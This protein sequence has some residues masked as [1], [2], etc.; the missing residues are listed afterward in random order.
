MLDLKDTSRRKHL[1]AL[2]APH[3]FDWGRSSQGSS[4]NARELILT[5]LWGQLGPIGVGVGCGRRL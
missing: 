2:G 3:S 5:I 4:I 1:W